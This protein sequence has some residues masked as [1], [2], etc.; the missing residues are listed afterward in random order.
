[1]QKM[2]ARR[3]WGRVVL[4]VVLLAAAS[5]ALFLARRPILRAAG[6]ALVV[7]DR[8]EPA[9]AI[10]VMVDADGAGVLEA[11]DLVH[12]GVSRQVAL[13][14]EDPDTVV[15][16]EFI[17][18]GIRY[19]DAAERSARELK[20]LGVESSDVIPR[21]VTGSEDE[22]PALADWCAQHG[23]RSVV[24]VS[25]SD[26]SRR[27]RR[28]LHR[29]MKGHPTKVTNHPARYSLF[30]PNRWWQSRRGIRTEVVELEKL[31]LDV[32]RHPIS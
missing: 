7:D 8:V 29:A 6:W 21:Y 13:F 19:E 32:V 16:R 31:L 11:A 27:L 2:I 14:E 18:R 28:V 25:T 23:F 26:H 10:V 30:D 15:E 12:G 1:M 4:V 24:V 5:V 22:G 17:R 9:D 20:A 3:P